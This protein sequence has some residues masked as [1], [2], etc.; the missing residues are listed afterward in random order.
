MRTER[1]QVHKSTKTKKFMFIIAGPAVGCDVLV[2]L[3]ALTRRAKGHRYLYLCAVH[4]EITG[5]KMPVSN[6]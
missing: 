4:D 2:L 6:L 3:V 5:Q 1:S